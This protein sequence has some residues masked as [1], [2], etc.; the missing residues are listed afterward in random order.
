M[1][2]DI[3]IGRKSVTED[4]TTSIRWEL[5]EEH[6]DGTLDEY[7]ISKGKPFRSMSNSGAGYF[8]NR[9]SQT[10]QLYSMIT[11][12]GCEN[13][14]TRITKEM[15]RFVTEI[16]MERSEYDDI[17]RDRLFWFKYWIPLA[18]ETFKDDAYILVF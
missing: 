16:D 1:T 10:R 11:K 5:T 14:S 7:S 2:F 4:G 17:D 15:A 6:D 13:V 12:N 18:Y 3:K 8:F 9:T